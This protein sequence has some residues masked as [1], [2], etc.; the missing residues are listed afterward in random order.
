MFCA[1]ENCD[2]ETVYNSGFCNAHYQRLKLYGRLETA[3]WGQTDHPL[4]ILWN[5]QK[6]RGFLCDEWHN[7][8]TF[9]KEVGEK[10]TDSDYKLVRVDKKKVL[11]PNNFK[12]LK[13]VK[14][15]EGETNKEFQSRRRYEREILNPGQERNRQ[16][17]RE[18]SITL[19]QY[20]EKFKA[21]HGVCKICG[22]PET[23][24]HHKSGKVKSLALDHDH[25][26][27]K[28]RDLLCQR[29]NRVLGKIRDSIELLDKMK[30]YLLD[31]S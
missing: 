18:F 12:W 23:T 7:F 29:C 9:I 21:Q 17:N 10:P 4:Y 8:K 16:L 11:G 26:T 28:I 19:E 5:A 22:E 20:N 27:K 1:A 31:H 15:R 2:R 3:V 25:D 24:K 6:N 14:L 30:A 13:Y